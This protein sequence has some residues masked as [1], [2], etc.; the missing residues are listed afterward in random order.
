VNRR[1]IALGFCAL[2]LIDTWTQIA[3]KLASKQTGEF[4]MNT[5]W[6]SAAA[7]SPFIYAAIAGYIGAFLAWMTL[8]EHAPVGPAFAASHL[9]VVT[10][11]ILSVPLFGERLSPGKLAGAACIVTGIILLSLSESRAPLPDHA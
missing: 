3:F 1:R 2:V 6:L 4:M 11:L 10:V 9:E 5:R 8:L 7:I